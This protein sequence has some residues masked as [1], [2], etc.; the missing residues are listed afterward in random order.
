[1]LCFGVHPTYINGVLDRGVYEFQQGFVDLIFDLIVRSRQIEQP[2][3]F[4]EYCHTRL[5]V[6]ASTLRASECP[7]VSFPPVQPTTDSVG[8][9]NAVLKTAGIFPSLEGLESI[10][11]IDEPMVAIEGGFSAAVGVGQ[12]VEESG[13]IG[14]SS[15]TEKQRGEESKGSGADTSPNA[16]TVDQAASGTHSRGAN[17]SST[18]PTASPR[19]KVTQPP[20]SPVLLAWP[21]RAQTPQ[22]GPSPAA[23]GDEAADKRSSGAKV[24]STTPAASPQL[25]AMQPL[26]SPFLQAG[27]LRDH[28]PPCDPSPAAAAGEA[29]EVD[30]RG[31]DVSSTTPT[32]SPQLKPMQPPPSPFLFA[33]P[34]NTQTSHGNPSSAAGTDKGTETCSPDASL[35]STTPTASPRLKATQPPPSPFLLAWPVQAQTPQSGPSTAAGAD[36]GAEK[37]SP[38]ASLSGTTPTASP[39]IKATQPPLSPPSPFIKNLPLRTRTQSKQPNDP[40]TQAAADKS[41]KNASAADIFDGGSDLSSLSSDEEMGDSGKVPQ[42]KRRSSRLTGKSAAQPMDICPPDAPT[43]RPKK[44][45]RKRKLSP[46]YVAHSSAK[47]RRTDGAGERETADVGESSANPKSNMERNVAKTHS[48][49]GKGAKGPLLLTLFAANPP[50][51]PTSQP[52]SIALASA[53]SALQEPQTLAGDESVDDFLLNALV[54]P[55]SHKL[56]RLDALTHNPGSGRVILTPTDFNFPYHA[57]VREPPI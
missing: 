26:P 48:K 3:P 45:A 14:S 31:A 6:L 1:M 23:G 50:E 13:R 56:L 53:A 47:K 2:G 44:N 33:W 34:L 12:S 37:R 27:P 41:G 52:E 9:H 19:L 40:A 54:R 18:T 43:K 17:G 57:Q 15:G 32:A 8:S 11:D 21:P 29:T 55:I 35:G 46:A 38:G 5:Q 22:S 36:K 24:D 51:L 10:D 30:S 20:P 28:T 7:S 4:W 42:A 16:T 25:K 39:R 49:Q